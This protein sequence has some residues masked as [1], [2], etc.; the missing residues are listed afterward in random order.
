MENNNLNFAT[1]KDTLYKI[2]KTA[3]DLL[4]VSTDLKINN[5]E[6][7][8]FFLLKKYDYRIEIDLLSLLDIEDLE[9]NLNIVSPSRVSLKNQ[10]NMEVEISKNKMKWSLSPGEINNLEFSFWYWNKLLIG[11]LIIVSI[12]SLAYFIKFYRYQIGSNLP[13]LPSD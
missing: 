4:G 3:G 2:Q 9:L 12:I 11:F 6:K 5:V 1:T 10:N 7:N 8:F 13:G